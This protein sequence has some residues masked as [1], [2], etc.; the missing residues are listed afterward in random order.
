LFDVTTKEALPRKDTRCV[1]LIL[2]DD[3]PGFLSFG[4]GKKNNIKHIASEEECIVTVHRTKGSDGK[5]SCHYKTV[6][7]SNA[8]GKVG[9]PG[10]DYEHCEG[11]LH[12]EHNETE[13]EVS[14]K[15]I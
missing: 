11:T 7:V 3:K 2:D 8:A 1:V 13:K 14:I 15:I 6:Q 5:I 10:E 4:E 12:F 9:V